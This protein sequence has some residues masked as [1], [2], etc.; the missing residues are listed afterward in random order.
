MTPLLMPMLYDQTL[1]AKLLAEKNTL[2]TFIFFWVSNTLGT[3]PSKICGSFFLGNSCQINW[4]VHESIRL[5]MAEAEE[6]DL[7][8]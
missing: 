8:W 2:G 3:I 7:S 1:N 5:F 6:I 4:T